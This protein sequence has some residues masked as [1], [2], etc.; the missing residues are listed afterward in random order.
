MAGSV[1]DDDE[2]V[3]S[4]SE[5]TNR[6]YNVA[7]NQQ[8]VRAWHPILDPWWVAVSLVLLGV[9]LVPVGTLQQESKTAGNQRKRRRKAFFSLS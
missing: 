1:H 2:S 9:I 6:P 3:L 5:Q 7:I 4:L 8:R